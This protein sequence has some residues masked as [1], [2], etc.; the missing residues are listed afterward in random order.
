MI[1]KSL[2]DLERYKSIMTTSS[3]LVSLKDINEVSEGGGESTNSYNNKLFY[4]NFEPYYIQELVKCYEEFAKGELN[5][6]RFKELK[7]KI[8]EISNDMISKNICPIESI[9]Y[10]S[11]TINYLLYN[12]LVVDTLGTMI[13]EIYLKKQIIIKIQ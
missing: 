11:K 6:D 10:A 13:A 5:Q 9:L 4:W 7:N 1:L 12:N 2:E 3:K 8:I